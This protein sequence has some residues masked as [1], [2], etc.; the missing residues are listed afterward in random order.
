MKKEKN[1]Y[2][3]NKTRQCCSSPG[4]IVNGGDCSCTTEKEYAIIDKD[5][6][7]MIAYTGIISKLG[8]KDKLK[9]VEGAQIQQ[10]ENSRENHVL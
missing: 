3:C 10:S 2:Y 5:G 9:L 8:A 4:C 1:V 6:N 7:P